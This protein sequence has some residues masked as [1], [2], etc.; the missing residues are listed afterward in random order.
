MQIDFDTAAAEFVRASRGRRS[1]VAMSRRL[2]FATN[3][4]YSWE[5]QKRHPTAGQLLWAL[6]RTGHDVPERLRAFFKR[7]CPWLDTTEP[8]APEGVAALVAELKGATQINELARTLGVSR[9]V[10]SRWLTG[11]T[12][13]SAGQLFELIHHYTHRVPDFVAE[14]TSSTL[15]SL[16]HEVARLT[17]ARDLA[18]THPWSQLVLRHLELTQ[19]LALPAHE[20]GWIAKRA[21]LTLEEEESSLQMLQAAGQVTWTGTHWQPNTIVALDLR[22]N[23]EAVRHQRQFWATV[24]S[25]RA[26][27]ST[28]AVCG[29]N[30]FT[31][32]AADYAQLKV[33][34]RE[35]M[36][37][38]RSLI[39]QSEPAERVALLQLNLVAFD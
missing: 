13:P 10:V 33:L 20:R 3:V 36:Q 22:D 6:H 39:T 15:P 7:A 28:D 18:R 17:A 1:Q 24:A 8:W 38:A 23:V 14:F 16:A 34:H 2:G 37:K 29:Y 32:S 4:V 9:F 21:K 25:Q 11:T 31:I 12:Q 35:F 5:R 30:V 26:P 27:H 19:Y